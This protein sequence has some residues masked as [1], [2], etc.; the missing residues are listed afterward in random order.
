LAERA[1]HITA[2][3]MASIEKKPIPLGVRIPLAALVEEV[4]EV[5]G[6]TFI[7]SPSERLDWSVFFWIA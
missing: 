5:S 7:C 6:G 1:A 3:P 2:I 4:R